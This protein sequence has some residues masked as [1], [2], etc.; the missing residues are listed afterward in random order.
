MDL[1]RRAYEALCRWEERLA[2][3]LLAVTVVVVLAGGIARF[4]AV[5]IAWS[6]E[7]AGFFF[8]WAAFFSADVALREN[9]HVSVDFFVDRLPAKAR[10]VIKLINYLVILVF[11]FFLIGYGFQMAY[12]TRFRAFQGIPGFSYMWVTLSVPLGS[13]L[14]VVTTIDKIRQTVALLRKAAPPVPPGVSRV[15]S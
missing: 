2:Q 9:R 11:L 10:T 12:L 4:A 13:L 1:V 3:V 14:L 6:M 8:A 15:G 7:V 5:P